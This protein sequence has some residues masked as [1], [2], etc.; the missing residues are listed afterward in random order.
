MNHSFD[1]KKEFD[2]KYFES[3]A[4]GPDE[5]HPLIHNEN[6]LVQKL[7]MPHAGERILD[8]GCGK[9]RL[10]LF[11]LSTE[12][13]IQMVFSDVSAESRKYLGKYTFVECSMAKMP[14]PDEYFDKVF[15]LHVISHIQ[16]STKAI[17]EAYRIL[18]KGGRMMILTPNKYYVYA[19]RVAAGFKL[20]PRVK[21]DP[22][23]RWLYSKR[24]LR[25]LLQTQR[26]Q[27]MKFSYFQEAP[28]SLPFEPFRAKVVSI[29]EK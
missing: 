14:F 27:S 8:I 10:G 11:L 12:Q 26:W 15:C 7:M 25:T 4:H 19:R 3:L 16:E 5:W 20:I 28:R 17:A 21:F 24:T 13:N 1:G 2:E 9:G 6:D 23:A 18:K 22:T 29:T